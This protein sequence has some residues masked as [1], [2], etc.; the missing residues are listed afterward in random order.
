[1]LDV[2]FTIPGW[3]SYVR[4]VILTSSYHW[5]C[6]CCR[7]VLTMKDIQHTHGL[8]WSFFTLVLQL[9]IPY[10]VL[11]V[12]R[13]PSSTKTLRLVLLHVTRTYVMML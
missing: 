7:L 11:L 8:Q 10:H 2:F 3:T 5:Y 1:M 4:V 9:L 6:Y 12:Y 13:M